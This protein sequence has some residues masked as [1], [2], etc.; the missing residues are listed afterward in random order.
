MSE[1]FYLAPDGNLMSVP[2]RTSPMFEPGDPVRLFP[3]H[4]TDVW[5]DM[6]NHYDV[7]LDGQRF[8]MVNPLEDLRA[9]TYTVVLNWHR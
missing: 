2:I 1:L 9:S 6:R 4:L 8:I 5:T 3:T 7:S